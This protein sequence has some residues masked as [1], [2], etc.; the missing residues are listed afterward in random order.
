M[1]IRA[2]IAA[3]LA[4][5]SAQAL[6]LSDYSPYNYEVF[7][8][9]PICKEYQYETPVEANDG[10]LLYAKPKN[11]YC[12][13]EDFDQN[14]LREDSPHYQL[15]KLINDKEVESL[16]FTFLSFSNDDIASEICDAIKRNVKVSFIIDSNNEDRSGARSALDLIA[17]CRP[18]NLAD[19]VEP[20][21][22][23]T[24]FRG[25]KSGIGYAHNKV[26][27]AKFKNSEKVKLVYGSGNMSSGTILHHENWHFVTTNQNTFLVQSHECLKKAMLESGDSRKEYKKTFKTCR[28]Q[29]MTPEEEDIQMMVVPSDGKRAM[30]NILANLKE[31]VA[32][33]IAVHRF[34][35]TDLVEGLQEAAK[36]QKKVRFIADDDIYW[37]GVRRTRTGSNLYYE[38]VNTMKIIGAGVEPRYIQSNQNHHLLHHNKYIVFSYADGTGA[39]HAGAGNFTKAAFSKNMENYYFI[40]IPSVV[41]VFK[42]QYD[43]M[44]NVIGT[45]YE[46]MPSQYIMP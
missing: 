10:T 18:E 19:G 45:S 24:Y 15:V 17:S 26:I 7:F 46:K 30:D 6:K 36:A 35:H 31:S 3:L 25:N 21:L 12:A 32:A 8:T 33:D 23:K 16:F 4:T 22:P 40:T 43:Y 28:S 41:E 11:A 29:I 9:N 42:K 44:F 39:V 14:A 2:I 38:F 1:I 5:S 13:R 27:I 37:T 34:T 20:N